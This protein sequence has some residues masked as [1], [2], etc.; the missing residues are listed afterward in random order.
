MHNAFVL[1]LVG[2]LLTLVIDVCN[3]DGFIVAV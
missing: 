3:H 2:L 1:A